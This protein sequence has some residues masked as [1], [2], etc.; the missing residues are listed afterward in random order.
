MLGL[1][2][3]MIVISC[4]EAS[5]KSLLIRFLDDAKTANLIEVNAKSS[6]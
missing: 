3:Y 1:M 5:I 4:V 2:L 6:S